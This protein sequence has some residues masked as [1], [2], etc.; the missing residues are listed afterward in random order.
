MPGRSIAALVPDVTSAKH[1]PFMHARSYQRIE[2]HL[3]VLAQRA[4]PGVSKMPHPV[5]LTQ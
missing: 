2:L 3:R 1:I 4:D 5:I